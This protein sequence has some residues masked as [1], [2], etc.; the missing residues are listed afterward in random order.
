VNEGFEMNQ[1]L[2]ILL[3]ITE[4]ANAHAM[5]WSQLSGANDPE[6]KDDGSPVTVVDKKL[7]QFLSDQIRSH[8]PNDGFVGEESDSHAVPIGLDRVWYVDP[9]DGTKEF[10]KGTNEWST[11]LGLCESNV[12]VLATV[13]HPT[14]NF[15]YYAQKG[16]GAFRRNSLTGKDEPLSTRSS[17]NPEDLMML[18]SQTKIDPS[19]PALMSELNIV[20]K[21]KHGSIGL[22][23]AVI[24][25]G[26]ADLYVNSH[27]WCS[28]WD[29][30]AS[31]L[32]LQ[33]S[34]GQILDFDL[35]PLKYDPK[36]GVRVDRGFI[37]ATNAVIDQYRAKLMEALQ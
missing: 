9:L 20:Q 10:V 27:G 21:M 19:E 36:L 25:R 26:D 15:V 17:F 30:V 6:I 2:E 37:M 32:I 31:D 24:A 5:E 28:Y 3:K 12:P 8:F 1:E 4:Q 23:A 18:G 11:I 35:N 14:E 33:E 29:L 22:K 13:G 16:K 7:N 34:G